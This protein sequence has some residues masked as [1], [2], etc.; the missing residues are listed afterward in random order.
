MK[1][2][3]KNTALLFEVFSDTFDC[4]NWCVLVDGHRIT[5]CQQVM[6][7]LGNLSVL[8]IHDA[9]LELALPSRLNVLHL[10]HCSLSA[11]AWSG[12]RQ[13]QR[14]TEVKLESVKLKKGALGE[15][16]SS[17]IKLIIKNTAVNNNAM[18][19]DDGESTYNVKELDISKDTLF[20]KVSFLTIPVAFRYIQVFCARECKAKITRL[21][22]RNFP[23]LFDFDASGSEVCDDD[24]CH[25]PRGLRRLSLADCANLSNGG[26]DNITKKLASLHY[27]DI[28]RC[29]SLTEDRVLKLSLIGGLMEVRMINIIVGPITM[30]ALKRALPACHFVQ[31]NL[32][33]DNLIISALQKTWPVWA[34]ITQRWLVVERRVIHQKFQNA[35]KKM[36]NLHIEAFKYSLPNLHKYSSP[37]KFC[38]IWL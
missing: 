3:F 6:D 28:S 17:V 23:F 30:A 19:A 13:A 2:L 4:H 38:Q 20:T 16:P 25:L 33:H 18:I 21:S 7:C 12:I 14:L 29:T 26:L 37:P 8:V 27:L 1:I 36:I 31:R 10:H 5:P 15:L 32:L 24:L 11:S 22:C 35:V 9:V 34:L